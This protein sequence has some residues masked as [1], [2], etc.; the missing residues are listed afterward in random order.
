[1]REEELLFKDQ[2]LDGSFSAVSPRKSRFFFL[3]ETFDLIVYFWK[4]LRR[5]EKE[6]KT[7]SSS[8]K[9]KFKDDIFDYVSEL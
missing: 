4:F 9:L 3:I 6:S 1:M 5:N 8:V 2:Q 7:I